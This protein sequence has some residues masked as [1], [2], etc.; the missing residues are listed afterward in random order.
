MERDVHIYTCLHTIHSCHLKLLLVIQH[1]GHTTK[2]GTPGEAML[3][4]TS[5]LCEGEVDDGKV[6]INAV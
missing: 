3:G 6:L 5:C 2:N 4:D 1:R